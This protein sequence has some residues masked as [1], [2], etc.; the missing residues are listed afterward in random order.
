MIFAQAAKGALGLSVVGGV[1][2]VS[3]FFGQPALKSVGLLP[4]YKTFT[5]KVNENGDQVT[6]QLFCREKEGLKLEAVKDVLEL[7][8]KLSCSEETAQNLKTSEVTCTKEGNLET[9]LKCSYSGSTSG[10]QLDL[11]LEEGTFNLLSITLKK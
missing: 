7:K 3:G 11:A 2:T 1:G 10:K 8:V 6:K 5:V 9:T 4:S